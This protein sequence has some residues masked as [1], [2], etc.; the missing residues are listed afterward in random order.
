MSFI[1]QEG[2]FPR[3]FKASRSAENL[4]AINYKK[5][6]KKPATAMFGKRKVNGTPVKEMNLRSLRSII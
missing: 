6:L 2:D 4:F 1:H 3:N 5:G